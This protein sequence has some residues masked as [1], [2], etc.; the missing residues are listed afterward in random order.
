MNDATVDMES[1]KELSASMHVE[2]P[3]LGRVRS[4]VRLRRRDR[5]MTMSSG[6]AELSPAGVMLRAPSSRFSVADDKAE[7][8]RKKCSE[9]ESFLRLAHFEWIS[10]SW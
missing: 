5:A 3:T 4:P 9:F 8:V 7:I 1:I 6:G 10:F 2:N